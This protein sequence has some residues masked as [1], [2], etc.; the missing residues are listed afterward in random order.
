LKS[1][2]QSG[3]PKLTTDRLLEMRSAL[4]FGMALTSH[5]MPLFPADCCPPTSRFVVKESL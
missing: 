3:W 2:A 5:P 4:R 1:I